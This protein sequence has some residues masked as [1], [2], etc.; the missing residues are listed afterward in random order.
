M[1]MR[2][3]PV[4]AFRITNNMSQIVLIKINNQLGVLTT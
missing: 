1:G 4:S 3:W 2:A